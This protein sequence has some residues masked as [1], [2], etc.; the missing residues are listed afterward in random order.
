VHVKGAPEQVADLIVLVDSY[1]L[2]QLGTAL[3]EKLVNV[4]TFLAANKPQRACN[5]LDRFL[6][7]VK[8]Q[9]GK[10]ISVERADRL[11]ADAERIKVVIGC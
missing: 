7:Q 11:T 5:V 1:K 4:Q 10:R 6:A 2:G 9:R 8:E 3:H